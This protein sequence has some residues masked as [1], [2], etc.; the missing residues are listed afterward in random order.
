MAV[1]KLNSPGTMNALS[2]NLFCA[3]RDATESAERDESVRALILTGKGRAFCA[4]GDLNRF[5][6]GFGSRE[7]AKDYISELGDWIRSFAAIGKPVIAAVNGHAAGAGFC[8]ALHADMIIASVDAKFTMSFANVGLIP[9]L[10]GLYAL[11]RTVGAMRA[12]ELIMTGRT[13]GAEEALNMGIASRVVEAGKLEGEALAVASELA[14]GPTEAFKAM[15][16]LSGLSFDMTLE[17]LLGA[18]AELQADCI[19]TE[20]HAGAVDSFFRKERPIFKGK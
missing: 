20:D 18:E 15:K 8:I 1:I 17:E 14:S 3:L 19:M 7:E 5:A 2:R 13:V 4:G 16:K 9:D 10:G 11:P 12:K 6:A